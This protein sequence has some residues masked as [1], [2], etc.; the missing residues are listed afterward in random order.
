MCRSRTQ[1]LEISEYH[2]T[3]QSRMVSK[4]GSGVFA[5]FKKQFH[6]E[7]SMPREPTRAPGVNKV[8]YSSRNSVFLF[9]FLIRIRTS[10]IFPPTQMCVRPTQVCLRRAQMCTNSY[11][12]DTEF[13]DE[14]KIF[15]TP[16][17]LV[18]SLGIVFFE[19]NPSL[20]RRQFFSRILAPSDFLDYWLSGFP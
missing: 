18:G 5:H 13:R 15:F 2:E 3:P 17:A 16:D 19:T 4:L 7:K 10:S 14:Y 1:N 11:E 12:K 9:F 8:M 6:L 20:N